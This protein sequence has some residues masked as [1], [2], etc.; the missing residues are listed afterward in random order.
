[1]LVV[2]AICGC[3]RDTR[4]SRVVVLSPELVRVLTDLGV[5][6]AVVGAD[7]RS[8][9]LLQ[10]A[11]TTCLGAF[12]EG[13]AARTAALDPG[14]VLAVAREPERRIVEELASAGVRV[15]L[16]DPRTIDEVVTAIRHIGVLVGRAER[17]RELTDQMRI[18]IAKTAM[19][20]DGRGR[21]KVLWL[22]DHEPRTVVG[23]AGLLHEMLELAGAENALH[24]AGTARVVLND[25]D[26]AA[27][28]YDA[29]VDTSAADDVGGAH[30][31]A[32]REATLT[33]RLPPQLSVLP[34][35]DLARRVR[36]LHDALYPPGGGVD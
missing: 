8:C 20:R 13:I 6:E 35:F 36:L 23:T 15:E 4:P 9:A 24:G 17:A 32:A 33:L 28:S 26:M 34:A 11:N 21:L 7:D 19:A 3:A 12:D 10:P 2:A 1:M 16:F 22:V 29:V 30:V 27:L 25:A 18:D 14:V 5:A 31:T